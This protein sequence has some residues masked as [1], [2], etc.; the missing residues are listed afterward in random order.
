MWWERYLTLEQGGMDAAD[1]AYDE[2]A[3]V[4][5]LAASKTLPPRAVERLT[6]DPDALVRRAVAARADLTARQIDRLARD[7]DGS[8]RA[9]VA[10]R[11]GL[12]AQ[13]G[14]MLADDTDPRV[15]DALGLHEAARIAREMGE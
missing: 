1:A 8:V 11:D 15:L 14:R 3:P 7:G 6:R 12:P 10:G 13:V 9:A 5:R 2:A 4:R